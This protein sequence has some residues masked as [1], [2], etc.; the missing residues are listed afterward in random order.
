MDLILSFIPINSLHRPDTT[1]IEVKLYC[2]I[3]WKL[4]GLQFE[5]DVQR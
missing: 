5:L 3:Y 2:L 4:K 1:S